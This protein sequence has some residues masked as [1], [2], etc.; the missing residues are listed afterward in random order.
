MTSRQSEPDWFRR[1]V[2]YGRANQGTERYRRDRAGRRAEQLLPPPPQRTRRGINRKRFWFFA[3]ALL[4]ALALGVAT[5]GT[6]FA[7]PAHQAGGVAPTIGRPWVAPITPPGQVGEP[8]VREDPVVGPARPSSDTRA[9]EPPGATDVTRTSG[10]GGAGGGDAAGQNGKSCRPPGTASQRT[11][12]HKAAPQKNTP[13]RT[14][15]CPKAKKTKA[16]KDRPGST[17]GRPK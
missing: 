3:G 10:I 17:K 6:V 16:P 12:P 2:R 1:A 4:I 11:A 13:H 15:A 7:A 9:S 8:W 14:A 5:L